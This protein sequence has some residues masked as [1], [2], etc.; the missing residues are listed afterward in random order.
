MSKGDPRRTQEIHPFKAHLLEKGLSGAGMEPKRCVVV[1]VLAP[2][3][4]AGA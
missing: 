4:A 1:G 3:G 2:G